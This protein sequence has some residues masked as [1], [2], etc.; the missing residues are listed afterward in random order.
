MEQQREPSNLVWVAKFKEIG[1]SYYIHIPKHIVKML[2]LMPGKLLRA[3]YN[4]K[5]ITFKLGE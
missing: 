3:E 4:N 1:N 2:N 5:T